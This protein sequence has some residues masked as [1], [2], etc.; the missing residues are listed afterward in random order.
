MGILLADDDVLLLAIGAILPETTPQQT[1]IQC[2]SQCAELQ[3][4]FTC[5][6]NHQTAVGPGPGMIWSRKL[7]VN[8][9]K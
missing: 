1:L 7:F 3:I 9:I 5:L 6:N 8:A 4:F 2:F